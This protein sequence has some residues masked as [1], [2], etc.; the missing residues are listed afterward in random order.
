MSTKEGYIGMNTEEGLDLKVPSTSNGI[1]KFGA[2]TGEAYDRNEYFSNFS[3]SRDTYN[4]EDLRNYTK[5]ECFTVIIGFSIVNKFYTYSNTRNIIEVLD[6][7]NNRV[8]SMELINDTGII[9]VSNRYYTND[10]TYSYSNR[11]YNSNISID[12]GGCINLFA[13]RFYKKEVKIS[14]I[15]TIVNDGMNLDVGYDVDRVDTFFINFNSNG[16]NNGFPQILVNDSSVETYES[17]SNQDIDINI[18]KLLSSMKILGSDVNL[19]R[20]KFYDKDAFDD[21]R[22]YEFANGLYDRLPEIIEEHC[23]KLVVFPDK[24][25]NFYETSEGLKEFQ[26]ENGTG[27]DGTIS[28]IYYEKRDNDVVSYFKGKTGLG[29]DI[30]LLR[31][32]ANMFPTIAE[33]PTIDVNFGTDNEVQFIIGYYKD[34]RLNNGYSNIFTLLDENNSKLLEVMEFNSKFYL[35]IKGVDGNVAFDNNIIKDM[36]RPIILTIGK[37]YIT[38]EQGINYSESVNGYEVGPYY[39]NKNIKEGFKHT[40]GYNI[41][42][43]ARKIVLGKN[44]TS[45]AGDSETDYAYF[46]YRWYVPEKVFS[47]N[48]H[49]Y[50]LSP[51]MVKNE[52]KTNKVLAELAIDDYAM[53][54]I[55]LVRNTVVP[56]KALFLPSKSAI[57]KSTGWVS[58]NE[59][60]KL[61]INNAGAIGNTQV[62]IGEYLPVIYSRYNNIS[63]NSGTF[64]N[65]SNIAEKYF[66][67]SLV[68]KFRL[69]DFGT[70]LTEELSRLNLFTITSKLPLFNG[71]FRDILNFSTDGNTL[72]YKKTGDYLEGVIYNETDV[73]YA[74]IVNTLKR[75]EYVTWRIV[76]DTSNIT[77]YTDVNPYN[78]SNGIV[79]PILDFNKHR[80]NPTGK[81]LLRLIDKISFADFR[82]YG[83]DGSLNPRM[84]I[85]FIDIY[86]REVKND[87]L[88]KY[89]SGTIPND[90]RVSL[91][92]KQ[93]FPA[94]LNQVT[95]VTNG[96]IVNTSGVGFLE[97]LAPYPNKN[98]ETAFIS[99]M[100]GVNVNTSRFTDKSILYV[101]FNSLGNDCDGYIN[102]IK[103]WFRDKYIFSALSSGCY[104]SQERSMRNAITVQ[105]KITPFFVPSSGFGG[106]INVI[107]YDTRFPI[108]LDSTYGLLW[109]EKNPK[110]VF[111]QNDNDFINGD[112]SCYSYIDKT[113]YSM[114][115]DVHF[116]SNPINP[117]YDSSFS[118]GGNIIAPIPPNNYING[119]DFLDLYRGVMTPD[120]FSY[121]FRFDFKVRTWITDYGDTEP[122]VESDNSVTEQDIT[123][124]FINNLG[125]VSDNQ[126]TIQDFYNIMLDDSEAFVLREL[127]T[128]DVNDWF[129]LPQGSLC[130]QIP[131]ITE[132][133]GITPFCN[134][135]I[136]NVQDKFTNFGYSEP[137][138]PFIDNEKEKAWMAKEGYH[139]LPF[140][141]FTSATILQTNYPLI[142]GHT[143]YFDS[144]LNWFSDKYLYINPS[145]NT[146]SSVGVLE[147]F[148]Y[149]VRCRA[150]YV[151]QE[152][153]KYGDTTFTIFS[154]LGSA[155]NFIEESF[156]MV[157]AET[158]PT[159]ISIPPSDI[160][161]TGFEVSTNNMYIKSKVTVGEM[162]VNCNFRTVIEE[163]IRNGYSASDLEFIVL[164]FYLDLC[165]YD[166][167]DGEVVGIVPGTTMNIK[168]AFLPTP[169][170]VSSELNLNKLRTFLSG[171]FIVRDEYYGAFNSNLTV[172]TV[173][174]WLSAGGGGSISNNINIY[175]AEDNRIYVTPLTS[176]FI[177]QVRSSGSGIIRP[178]DTSNNKERMRLYYAK[179]DSNDGYVASSAITNNSVIKYGTGRIPT[180]SDLSMFIKNTLCSNN[181][182]DFKLILRAYD[183]DNMNNGYY[184]NI[185][186]S[187]SSFTGTLKLSI[188]NTDNRSVVFNEGVSFSG[189]DGSNTLFDELICYL[190]TAVNTTN[191]INI[192]SIITKDQF[193]TFEGESQLTSILINY[194]EGLVWDYPG[195]DPYDGSE[196][197]SNKLNEVITSN[198]L[199]SSNTILIFDIIVAYYDASS[200]YNF[201]STNMLRYIGI[202]FKTLRFYLMSNDCDASNL[203]FTPQYL[204]VKDINVVGSYLNSGSDLLNL[205]KM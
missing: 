70:S 173:N 27:S 95:G 169:I 175:C 202:A 36:F 32:K 138:T 54:Y 19:V 163:V 112:N 42:N 205:R 128:V 29:K 101:N 63:N 9:S 56:R 75:G 59:D 44:F 120:H 10:T 137:M 76:I 83:T 105:C 108:S 3:Y 24:N 179:L 5:G 17:V 90:P 178:Q 193:M 194:P 73:N 170:A 98:K 203:E 69:L 192:G 30:N 104:T 199:N 180:I 11:M 79:I 51:S 88:E 46:F 14:K 8:F 172:P 122:I 195:P 87:E 182:S 18:L 148:A 12:F 161:N 7:S 176:D 48:G 107:N 198:S 147:R 190:G 67:I 168:V 132:P 41:T 142:D 164:D 162:L 45:S 93:K 71:N 2:C 140:G 159:T 158:E 127:R 114:L 133:N 65:L 139:Y 28:K 82:P 39:F 47:V 123:I 15:G 129:N 64:I 96:N 155:N 186:D 144:I 134:G 103:N 124:L 1:L 33:Y 91:T 135:N 136:I 16:F 146:R 157:Y 197:L 181:Y 84:E 187:G 78:S 85:S 31:I 23:Q 40:V 143:D 110:Y 126:K 152:R 52:F 196:N 145:L 109:G 38:I 55:N 116:N 102:A 111:K 177:E 66:C 58:T 62:N 113:I 37:N 80:T 191:N 60:I 125:T 149:T 156:S 94:D 20:L 204:D 77:I 189:T 174:T 118:L 165:T 61:E 200:Y 68:I 166:S 26:I 89:N 74:T 34:S 117:E 171:D 86:D 97:P 4:F 106:I 188:F 100:D 43:N 92:P 153:D 13:I 119:L 154:S 22:S 130:P 184:Y 72:K 185:A 53:Y 150:S 183:D 35:S 201:A 25:N 160:E 141:M 57:T 115:E 50:T 81:S 21:F 49:G 99:T 121:F 131:L 6:A 167:L 151:G